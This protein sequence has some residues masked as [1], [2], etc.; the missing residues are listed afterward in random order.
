MKDPTLSKTNL[1]KIFTSNEKK[2]FELNDGV[3]SRKNYNLAEKKCLPVI[4]KYL[5]AD[6]LYPFHDATTSGHLDFAKIYD[7]IHKRFFGPKICRNIVRYVMH[8]WECQRSS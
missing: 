7:R 3:L 4:P 2:N 5:R 6:I 1:S 8:C